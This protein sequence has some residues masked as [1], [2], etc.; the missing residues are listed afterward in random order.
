MLTRFL[1]RVA[2]TAVLIAIGLMASAAAPIAIM[3]MMARA[4]REAWR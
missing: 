1:G 2:A 3:G 4:I